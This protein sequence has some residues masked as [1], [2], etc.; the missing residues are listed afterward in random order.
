MKKITFL[1]LLFI[2]I[3]YA[4]QHR[5]GL[6]V[7]N[8]PGNYPIS[9]SAAIEFLSN[10]TNR[11]VFKSDFTTIQGITLE[12]FLSTNPNITSGSNI[13]I[14]NQ[15]LQDDNGG[16]DMSDPIT[17]FKIFDVPNGVNITDYDYI[18]I[19]CT[20]ANLLWGHVA[21]GTS[22]AL[23]HCERWGTFV[24]GPQGATYPISGTA[25]IE[26]LTDG[27][28]QVI[29]DDNLDTVQGL[30]LEVF[31]SKTGTLNV[32]SDVKISSQ[33]LQ[34]NNGGMDL[35]DP[36][37]GYKIFEVPA[38]IEL[39]DYN[40]IL[41]QCTSA[42]ILWGNVALSANLGTGCVPLSV[43]ENKLNTLYVYP[44]PVK[45]VLQVSLNEFAVLTAEVY[46]I[47]GKKMASYNGIRNEI[48]LSRL[49]PGVYLIVLSDGSNK[50]V[51]KIVKI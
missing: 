3:T 1:L 43:E 13:K 28:K 19:Q 16:T 30:Q 21:L 5:S 25:R 49:P 50:I 8:D 44:N 18:I 7:A 39:E 2:N 11:V 48:D 34:D 32:S 10:G 4:Q 12:V 37:T 22:S 31:L 27:T 15:Q 38:N 36:I 6:F 9:G 35:G 41:I 45:D 33:P 17:G 46:S 14:S 23:N 24:E 47:T 42:N 51:N 40:N 20:S 29:F 26:F